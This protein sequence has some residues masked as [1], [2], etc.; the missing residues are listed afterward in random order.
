MDFI[1]YKI[2]IKL[3]PCRQFPKD[4]IVLIVILTQREWGLQESGKHQKDK[5]KT[6]GVWQ[7]TAEERKCK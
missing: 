3:C 4:L 6:S 7:D 2:Y 1:D 5:V